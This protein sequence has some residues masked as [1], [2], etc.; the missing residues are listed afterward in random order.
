[1]VDRL[2]VKKLCNCLIPE[3]DADLSLYSL[4]A[5][6]VEVEHVIAVIEAV[7]KDFRAFYGGLWVGG[8]ALLTTTSLSFQ[9]NKLNRAVHKGDY[10]FSIP[11]DEISGVGY[12]RGFFTSIV[13]VS[14]Q[15][16]S[17]KLR[18]YGARRFQKALN[19]ARTG[20]SSR[21]I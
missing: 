6:V 4:G 14:T 12:E 15:H 3:A 8:S 18:C 7:L 11:L 17:F 19:D 21:A 20:Y 10:S 5:K 2:I 16:G 1:M 13:V 9:P